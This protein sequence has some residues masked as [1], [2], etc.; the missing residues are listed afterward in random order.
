[1]NTEVAR[2]KRSFG[3]IVDVQKQR[4]QASGR[5]IL[6]AGE[7]LVIP[8]IQET[9]LLGNPRYRPAGFDRMLQREAEATDF[10]LIGLADHAA[11]SGA[12]PVVEEVQDNIT[13][14]NA[15]LPVERKI[16]GARIL[17]AYNIAD[18]NGQNEEIS[19]H[20]EMLLPVFR[21]HNT[22]PLYVVRPKDRH[23]MPFDAFKSHLERQKAEIREAI[24]QNQA[25]IILPEG[26]VDAGRQKEGG[27]PGERNGMVKL[28]HGS[29]SGVADIALEQGKIPLFVFMGTSEET[30]LY[31]P[32]IGSVPPEAKIKAVAAKL[33][34]GARY[35]QDPSMHLVV[36]YPVSYATI[37]DYLGQNGRVPNG[38][39]EQY[40]GERIFPLIHPDERGQVYSRPALIDKVPAPRTTYE[41]IMGNPHIGEAVLTDIFSRE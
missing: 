1:M 7:K 4:V 13:T 18:K 36:D 17:L 22:E 20:F 41:A 12:M 32:I 3:E 31:D 27:A 8:H 29:V 28:I 38:M 19:T 35:L 39:I 23:S 40:C 6:R 24:E 37:A 16:S 14:I 15:V 30:S 21:K 10:V 25:I 26:T 34:P 33:I 9:V 11:H 2:A 5:R